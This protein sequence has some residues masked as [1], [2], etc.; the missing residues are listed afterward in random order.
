MRRVITILA[1]TLLLAVTLGFSFDWPAIKIPEPSIVYD[2]NGT[3][4]RG[5]SEQNQIN[6]S[7]EEIPSS[8]IAAVIAIEDKNFYSHHGV[9]FTGI[10]RALYTNIRQGKVAAGGSTITQQT[11]KNLFLTN[12]RTLT[13]KIK[14]LFYAIQLER[15]YSKDEI[16]TMYCNTI[17]FG[18]G[19]YGVEVAARTFFGKHARELTLAES[20]LL[21][22]LPQRPSGYNPYVNAE[23]AQNRQKMV[24]NRMVEESMITAVERD[25]ALQQEL[26]YHR[27]TYMGGDA[28]YFMAM[29]KDYLI[30]KYGERM[31]FQGGL[32]VYT[33]LDLNLQQAANQAYNQG[34]K[35]WDPQLQLALVA[36]DTRNGQITALIGGRDYAASSYNRAYARRQ[37]GSTFKPFMYS[38]AIER[39]FSAADQIQCEEVEFELVNGDIYKPTDYGSEP[40]HWRAFTLKEA[41]M[42]SDNVVA[43]QVNHILGPKETAAHAEKF[44]FSDLQP[45]LSLPLGSNEVTPVSMAAAYAVFANQGIYNEP[46]YILR[47][48]NAQGTVLEEYQAAPQQIISPENAYI[49][50]NMLQGVMDSGG[51]GHH[52]RNTI[53]TIPAAGKTGTTDEFKDAWF[54]GYTP[55]ICCA[56]WVG[57]D[58]NKN[59]SST[60]GVLAGPIWANFIAR[61]ADL[62]GPA[63]FT[64]PD[65]VQ[66]MNICLDSGQV[67]TQGC[68]RTSPMAFAKG[69]EPAGICYYHAKGWEWLLPEPDAHEDNEPWWEK[70]TPW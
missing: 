65:Q 58:R 55:R 28:P 63:D 46:V 18:Q 50:N 27:S 30:E 25:K 35:D 29:V 69:T 49:I 39:G 36:L 41:V 26:V 67:A 40:Y 56:V 20:A 16:L 45:V 19:A 11:A 21:A 14:E 53:G 23:A 61:T 9:D 37:P 57:Y 24:L 10:L 38:L 1:L 22:G 60:G 34:T 47:V 43:V 68:S 44:G 54:V 66:I 59:V 6:I 4:M 8:F 64:K 13:R 15:Q 42:I 3:P 31:V 70:W 48:E 2:I 17:Y 12:E 5:L 51:T 7:L 52:L 62:Y 33:T 32:R